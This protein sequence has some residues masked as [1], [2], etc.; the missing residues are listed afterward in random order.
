MTREGERLPAGDWP[1]AR[2]DGTCEMRARGVLVGRVAEVTPVVSAC[3]T[4]IGSSRTRVVCAVRVA[5]SLTD[6]ASRVH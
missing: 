4:T 3:A 2:G 1:D 5:T 6:I